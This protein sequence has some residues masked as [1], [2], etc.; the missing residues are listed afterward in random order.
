MEAVKQAANFEGSMDAFFAYLRSDPRFFLPNTDAGRDEYLRLAD[1]YLDGMAAR[2]PAFFGRL[3]KAKIV[4]RRVESF[5]EE[6]GG[7]AHYAGSSKDGAIPGIYY[8]HLKDMSAL[9]LW[10]LEAT[11]YHEGIP[12]HHMQ[13][14]I[15]RELEGV[16]R[17]LTGVVGY[18]AFS[19]G[20]ALYSELLAKEMGFYR[21]P[22]SDFGR[23]TLEQWRAVRLVVDTGL[24]AMDWSED[25]AV[26]Y[27]LANVPMPEAAVRSEVQRYLTFPGQAVSYKIGMMTMQRLRD[28]ARTALGERF[29]MRR[30]HDVV[31]GVGGVPLP[32]LE[33]RVERWIATGG[34]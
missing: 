15:G 5:R 1:H 9:P 21:D 7:A 14:A 3:P 27:F 29:D 18:G 11:A 20:W 30:F 4:V 8:V 16:P 23:L 31:L 13:V 25:E 28:A 6:A 32:V 19:E 34:R 2:L 17:L 33:D 24:H 22:I 26:R 10:Q 12:G